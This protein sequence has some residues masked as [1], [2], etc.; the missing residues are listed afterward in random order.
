MTERKEIILYVDDSGSRAPD[1][2]PAVDPD[3][4]D[5]FALGGMLI[6]SSET[7]AAEVAIDAF[8][9]RWPQI[10]VGP[11]HSYHIR[12][13]SR[14]FR[15][16]MSATDEV[17]GRF[18]DQLSS[19]ILGLPVLVH[20][21]VVDRPGYNRRYF[22]AYRDERW[23]LCRT[24]FT[25][26]VERA[27]KY[28][29]YRGAR[30]RVFVE[31]TNVPTENQLKRYFT[32][33]RETGLPFDAD[34]SSKYAP[35][36]ADHLRETLLEFDTR[37]KKS[38]LMQIADLVLW[39]VCIAGYHP[40]NRNYVQLVRGGKLLDCICNAENGLM[41]IKYSCFDAA[42]VGQGAEPANEGLKTHQPARAG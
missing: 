11:L 30:L 23:K 25:I 33:L 8:R 2:D 18:Y 41:G 35:L 15:W 4:V 42:S 39:P 29:R 12:N 19:L 16:L 24:A 34:R 7:P 38:R 3:G 20:A 13:R 6:D 22:D 40:D 1:R 17:R 37:T 21:C 27:A 32:E 36:S 26:L 5:W 28:A 31:R 10:G 14:N 9:A